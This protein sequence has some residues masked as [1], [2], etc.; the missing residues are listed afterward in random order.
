MVE[1]CF[2]TFNRS[3]WHGIE[4]DLP[5]QVDA[6]AAAGFPLFGPDVFSLDA[7]AASGGQVEDLAARLDDRGLRCFEI[8]GIEIADEDTTMEHARHLV[9]LCA[10]LHPEWILTNVVTDIDDDLC[11]RFD[12]VCTMLADVGCRPAI[13]YLPFTPARSIATTKVLIDRVGVDRAKI[14]F[15]TWHHFRGPDTWAEL[16]AAPLELVAYVQFDDAYPVESDDLVQETVNNRAFPGEGEFELDR[17]CQSMRDKGFDGVVSVEILND[18]LRAD[19]DLVAFA[20]RAY[21]TSARYWS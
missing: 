20:R 13:E 21:T 10:V 5:G 15:D 19:P 3:A 4:P 2:N 12:R 6:A 7:L 14:L 8:S 1:F 17:Y 18:K 9:D 16:D 11:D